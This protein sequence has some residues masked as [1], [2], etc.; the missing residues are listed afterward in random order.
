MVIS[1]DFPPVL[2][3]RHRAGNEH[4]GRTRGASSVSLHYEEYQLLEIQRVRERS[5]VEG[6]GEI[7]FV[8]WGKEEPP[9]PRGI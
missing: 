6:G 8:V 7:V 5:G 1:S 9:A 4:G 2:F 3:V